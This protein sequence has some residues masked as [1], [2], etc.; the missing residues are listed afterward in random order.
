M[1]VDFNEYLKEALKDPET[2][3]N[4]LRVLN[5]EFSEILTQLR[6]SQGIS[7]SELA[8]HLGISEEW[9]KRTEKNRGLSLTLGELGVYLK[10]LGLS[11]RVEFLNEEGEVLGRFTL[12]PDEVVT[13]SSF[14]GEDR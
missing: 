13:R 6:E 4:Y 14:D 9:V 8:G 10:G 1:G 3:F 5:E 7:R 12:A 11:L 2:S